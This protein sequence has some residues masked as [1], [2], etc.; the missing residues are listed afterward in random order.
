MSEKIY[1]A[2]AIAGVGQSRVI[3]T[4]NNKRVW[5]IDFDAKALVKK[6]VFPFIFSVISR[7]DSGISDAVYKEFSRQ[8]EGLRLDEDGNEMHKL[9]VERYENSFKECT[10]EERKYI[11]RMLPV[12]KIAAEI[13]EENFYF[14]TYNS[15]GNIEKVI[16]ELDEFIDNV[17]KKRNVDKVNLVP[18]SLGGTVSTA[19]LDK[20]ADKNN[21]NKVVGVVP[22]YDGSSL[23]IGL[24]EGDFSK[25]EEDIIPKELAKLTSLLTEQTRKNIID[26]VFRALRDVVIYRTS[27]GWGAVPHEEYERLSSAYKMSEKL[28]KICDGN[29]KIRND[30]PAFI[31]KNQQ[32]GV[33]FF[34]LCGYGLPMEKVFRRDNRHSD[35]I[36]DTASCTMGATCPDLE[37]KVDVSTSAIKDRVWLYKGMEH[38]GAAKTDHLLRLCGLLLKNDDIKSVHDDE[39]F[40][41]FN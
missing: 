33:E 35:G 10:Q 27:V 8:I 2:I 39:N 28:R 38:E 3:N 4:E 15:F 14:F 24:I 5:P 37:K 13:G 25:Y 11:K 16:D 6:I 19:Y 9:K 1:P 17:M 30:F 32:K 7:K 26:S 34:S 41:Q 29:F 12:D 31:E 40:K 20:Y 21:I 36:V 18:V 22:A 23:V